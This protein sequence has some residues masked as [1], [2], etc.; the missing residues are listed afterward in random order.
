MDYLLNVKNRFFTRYSRSNGNGITPDQSVTA[1]NVSAATRPD[2]FVL[3]WS[4]E[5]SASLINQM[6]AGL[7]RAPSSV[8]VDGGSALLSAS[9]LLIVGSA[10]NSAVSPGGLVSLIGGVYGRAA[11]YK[12]RSWN[13]VD[14]LDWLRGNHSIK[15]GID[16]RAI[17]M[18]FQTMGGTTYQYSTLD[19]LPVNNDADVAYTPD[20]PFRTAQGKQFGAY[21]ED[22]WRL[23]SNLTLSFGLRYE[24]FS[25][26]SEQQNRGSIF[27][28]STFTF[29]PVNGGFFNASKLG[30]VPRAALAW[31]PDRLRG[32]TVFRVGAG[33][34]QGPTA[35]LDTVQPIQNG[36]VPVFLG[37]ASFPQTPQSLFNNPDAT[38]TPFALDTSS[39]VHPQRNMV[40]SGSVQQALPGQMVAQIGYLGI[41]SRHL[42]QQGT[43]NLA[44]GVDP[45]TGDRIRT[46][47]QFSAIQ[48]LT[49]GGNSSYNALQL[50][51]SRRLV[52][53]PTLSASYN[54]AH[55]I[56]DSFGTGET[57]AAQNPTC[58]ACERAS[59]NFDVR[60]TFSLNSV[61]ELPFGKNRKY[62]NSGLIASLA[63]GWSLAG[64]WNLRSGLPVNV[65]IQRSDEIYRLDGVYYSPYGDI[66]DGAVAVTNVPYGGEDRGVERPNLVAGVNPYVNKS[67]TW[68]LNP[69]AFSI[70]LP[71]TIGNL[72]R[73]ALRGPGF[74]QIDLQISR[75]FRVGEK[76]RIDLRA[77]AFNLAN[78]V[79]FANPTSILPDSLV[80][81][82]PGS[83][84]NPDLASSFGQLNS[85]VG[86]TVGLGTSRQLQ[87]S[88]RYQF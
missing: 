34:Y 50:G 31:S 10:D 47:D 26:T 43:T 74:S 59:N 15:T 46:S 73:N 5:L 79:N 11:D 87:L 14:N 24:Y 27:D 33:I 2:Q 85:T 17:V 55:S 83:A 51:L 30:F 88:L 48:Y 39:F 37:G 42:T 7:N 4:S 41:L 57:Q 84:L 75:T 32:D 69:A 23:R 62:L 78:H 76:H 45:V 38:K 3:G 66:P 21:V 1:R 12:G 63:A 68:F 28:L 22:E 25:P 19:N 77:E 56:G 64:V 71:G 61:Y 18:P 35:I 6:T 8:G 16:Y 58:L 20:L 67:G 72:G 65:L 52:N 70:P 82:K 54:W 80:D 9:R 86:R 13:L 36:A 60:N 53:G 44:T 40:F 81:V 29:Q 49:N